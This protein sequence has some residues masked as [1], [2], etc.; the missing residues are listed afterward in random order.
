MYAFADDGLGLF[1]VRGACEFGTQMRLHGGVKARV[2]TPGL[3]TH[4]DRKPASSHGEFAS[5]HRSRAQTLRRFIGTRISVACPRP[6]RRLRESPG[7]G[8]GAPPALGTVPFDELLAGNLRARGAG[9]DSAETVAAASSAAL[10]ERTRRSDRVRYATTPAP[11]RAERCAAQ[12]VARR[13]HGRAAPASRTCSRP[14]CQA[15]AVRATAAMPR[16]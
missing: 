15:L 5:A 7:I 6:M 1:A 3:K 2:Q 10:N 11:R 12:L 14:S 9:S 4:A 8:G 13:T 16:D